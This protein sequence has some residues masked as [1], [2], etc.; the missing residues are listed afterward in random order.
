MTIP[1]KPNSRLQKYRLTKMRARVATAKDQKTSHCANTKHLPII[2]PNILLIPIAAE[3]L[4]SAAGYQSSNFL[5]AVKILAGM[6]LK[7]L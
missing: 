1:S 5:K 4:L 2:R 6:T 3:Q 7:I